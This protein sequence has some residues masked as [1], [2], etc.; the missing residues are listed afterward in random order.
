MKK[1]N[2]VLFADDLLS[3]LTYS[4]VLLERVVSGDFGKVTS[5]QSTYLNYHRELSDR[6][7]DTLRSK[8]DAGQLKTIKVEKDRELCDVGPMVVDILKRTNL[9]AKARGVKLTS[10]AEPS[11]PKV[12][13]EARKLSLA[14]ES[15]FLVAIESAPKNSTVHVEVAKAKSDGPGVR[16][17]ASCKVPARQL[18]R[19]VELLGEPIEHFQDEF[20]SMKTQDLRLLLSKYTIELHDGKVSQEHGSR[21]SLTIIFEI[22]GATQ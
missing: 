8:L 18:D 20:K 13:G 15:V 6:M 21:G 14:F 2:V 1:D 4:N 16:I 12:Q 10:S 11:L 17:E 19:M 7:I 22:P 9:F 5:A 3:P